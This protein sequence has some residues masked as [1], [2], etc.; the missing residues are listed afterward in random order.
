MNQKQIHDIQDRE[1]LKKIFKTHHVESLMHFAGLKAVGEAEE[2]PLRYFTNN[3][4]GSIVLFD[5]TMKA[6]VNRI[7]FSS[8]ATVYGAATTVKYKEDMPLNPINV[9]GKTK[10]MVEDIL[11]EMKRAYPQLGVAI[12]RYFNPVG[13]H[14]TGWI[15]ENPNGVPN[16]LMPYIADVA[17][18]IRPKLFIY[19][20]DYQT[21][22]GTGLRDYIHVKD[23]ALGHI[24]ALDKLE[25]TSDLIVVNLGTGKPYSVLDL[26]HAFEKA[27][28]RVI[29]YEVIERRLGDLAEYYAD[30]KFAE[31]TL[32]WKTKLDIQSMCEDTWRWQQNRII[33]NHHKG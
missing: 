5:E 1:I 9:Y 16:N 15:G 25:S 31:L 23:L 22:D 12:L 18:G 19:G 27:S 20:N 17:F 13:A 6:S 8:S 29:P 10:L 32:E 14:P 4:S 26:V 21:P 30:P 24:A 7:I 33:K 3:V 11:R 2:K 28:Q